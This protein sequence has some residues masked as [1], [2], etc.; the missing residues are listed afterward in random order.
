LRVR[1]GANREKSRE[2]IRVREE[3]VSIRNVVGVR[4]MY[5]VTVRGE[6]VVLIE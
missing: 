4:P 1:K 2:F 5:P 6:E 3:P